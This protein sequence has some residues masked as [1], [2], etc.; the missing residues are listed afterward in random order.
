MGQ[1]AAVEAET[2]AV[3]AAIVAVRLR[4]HV[5]RGGVD[6]FKF[7]LSFWHDD[8]GGGMGRVLREKLAT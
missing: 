6:A 5:G 4:W 3:P 2:A 1:V 7:P 8:K